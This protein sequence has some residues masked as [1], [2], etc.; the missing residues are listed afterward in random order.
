MTVS[1]RGNRG[2]T[3]IELLVVIAIIAVL[4]G[5]L[6]PAVQKV[7]EAAART[8][9]M[10]NLE[11]I[12]KGTFALQDSKTYLPAHGYPW[13]KPP[14]Q[15]ITQCSV[16]WAILPNLEQDNMYNKA[17]GQPSAIFNMASTPVPVKVYNCPSDITNVNGVN[18]TGT[19]NVNSYSANGQVFGTGRYMNNSVDIQDGLSNTVSYVEHIAMCPDPAGGN[20]ATAGQNVWPA[21]N[22]T[23]GD[24]IVYWTGETTGTAPPGFPGGAS[25]YPTAMIPD[26]ANGN[27]LSW[28]VPQTH[29]TL[30]PGGNCDPLTASSLHTAGVL[31]AM[32]DGSAKLVAPN[33]SLK[34]WNA[35][36]TPNGRDSL[37]SDW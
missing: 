35:A 11:Q 12:G 9:C 28:K 8:A 24:P 25:A 32:A 37:G 22:L 16:F 7:R 19:W 30:N 2:F 15:T 21:V 10:N 13:P 1:R 34:T 18:P 5:L 6:M 29:P 26:P 17:A 20:T 3:L 36:L 33:I 31:V 14:N 23:T 27:V 4:V